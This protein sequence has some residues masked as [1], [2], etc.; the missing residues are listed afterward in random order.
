VV[1]KQCDAEQR[2]REQD[3]INRNA[4]NEHDLEYPPPHSRTRRISPP[5]MLFQR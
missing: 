3:E 5:S 1:M 4:E 2:Q